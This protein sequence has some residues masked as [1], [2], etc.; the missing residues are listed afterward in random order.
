[1]KRIIVF[2]ILIFGG[3]LLL[4][5][6][7]LIFWQAWDGYWAPRAEEAVA[8]ASKAL[9]RGDVPGNVLVY[10]SVDRPALSKALASGFHVSGH[11]AIGL[12][13]NGYEIK[14]RVPGDGQYNFDASRINGSW[15][16]ACCSHWSEEDILSRAAAKQ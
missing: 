11:D 14:V 9:A 8:A 4:V 13:L 7:P 1:M 12:S 5:A 2:P 3:L 15:E 6:S 16:L 10:A